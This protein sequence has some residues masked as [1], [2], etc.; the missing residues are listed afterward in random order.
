MILRRTTS[1]AILLRVLA[2]VVCICALPALQLQDVEL[3]SPVGGGRFPAV[4][5]GGQPGS[6]SGPADMGEDVD[7]C[8][9]S[10]GPSEYDYY[11]VVDPH[12][13]FAALASEFDQR[14]GRFQ[15]ELPPEAAD[16]VRKEYSSE[17]EIDYN[18]AFQYAIKA[19]RAMGRPPPERKTFVVPQSSI[20]VEK[21]Y[22]LALSS[23]ERRG[24]RHVVLAKLALTG[25]W[26]LRCRAQLPVTHQELSGGFEELNSRIAGKIKDGEAFD[27][28]KWT[29]VYQAILDS[30]GLSREGYAVCATTLF[31]FLL[32]GGDVQGCKELVTKAGERLGRDDK[33]DV[34]RGLI[35]ERKRLLEDHN[36]LLAVAAE[37]F[38]A[39]LRAEEIVRSRIPE[40]LLVVGE[41]NRRL[42]LNERA[43][44]WYLG[45]GRLP[46][47]QP[48]ARK[49]MRFEGKVRALPADKPYH[50]Q[51]GWIADEQLEKLMRAGTPHPG[52]FNGPDRGLLVAIVNEGLGSS[53]YNAP[54]WKPGTGGTQTD[55]AVVLDLVGKGILEQAFRLGTWPKTLGELWEREVV[56][57]RNRVNRFNCPVTGKPLVYAEPPG[58]LSSIA[59]STV[60]VATSAPIATPDGP[61]FAAFCANTRL[62]WTET[63]PAI[64]QPLAPR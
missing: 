11:V 7:G 54:G 64:G 28:A 8:R 2:A 18:H 20:P 47:T 40:I 4:V 17:R 55:C 43:C 60:L 27:L 53:N 63:A 22:R 32:R 30:D 42:G 13:Y 10:S 31:G 3:V 25:A 46:E 56:R 36:R 57:D 14:T 59:P 6:M 37:R 58:D 39:A 34:L 51:L 26:A 48:V 1:C 41:C 62:V 21:R 45:L 29:G 33:P 49:A 16:W 23:Y 44:D 61:R 12:T 19:S 52:E 35:R 24:A 50:V 15:A 9:H 5:P 38:V